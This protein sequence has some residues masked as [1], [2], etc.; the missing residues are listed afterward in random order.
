M[1]ALWDRNLG[2][3][4]VVE[5]AELAARPDCCKRLPLPA[6]SSCPACSSR[7]GIAPLIAM[8]YGTVPVVRATGGMTD[9]VFDYNH[10]TRLAYRAAGS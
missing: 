9:T 10:P 7:A 2:L 1:H 8:R 4:R 5:A 3:S 6:G